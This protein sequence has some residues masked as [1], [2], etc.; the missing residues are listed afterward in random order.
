MTSWNAGATRIFGYEPEEMIGQ[1]II[2]LIPPGLRAEEEAILARLRRGE[3]IDH[4]DTERVGKDGRRR[5]HLA[6]GLAGAQ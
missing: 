4:F 1:S 2:R 6:H 5:L 3:R